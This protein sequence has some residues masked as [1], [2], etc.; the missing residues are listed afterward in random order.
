MAW[1]HVAIHRL[2]EIENTCKWLMLLRNGFVT[3]GCEDR[4]T[5]VCENEIL[6]PSVCAE[7]IKALDIFGDYYW[8]TSL[9]N[10][11]WVELSCM[12]LCTRAL[13]E[14]YKG[15]HVVL[16][17]QSH[18]SPFVFVGLGATLCVHTNVSL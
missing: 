6:Q 2:E 15:E 18:G 11:Q 4:A 17:V 3:P 7:K 16:T 14:R 1:W 5:D 12:D 10:T 8:L 9:R 13:V